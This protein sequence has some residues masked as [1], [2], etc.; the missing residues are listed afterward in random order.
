MERIWLKSYPAGVPA[1]I[2]PRKFGSLVELFEK[3]I[4]KYRGRPAFHSMGKSI[5]F[6]DLDKRSRDEVANTAGSSGERTR[7]APNTATHTVRGNWPPRSPR[8]IC[9]SRHRRSGTS[10]RPQAAGGSGVAGSQRKSIVAR[11]ASA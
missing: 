11:S 6:D 9:V 3:S 5:T 2:E 7:P 4:A 10:P 8:M 1:D